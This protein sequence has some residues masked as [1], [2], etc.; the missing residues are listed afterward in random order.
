MSE[1]VGRPV[2]GG[3]FGAEKVPF[4]LPGEIL[5][6][7]V[8][9]EEVAGRRAARCVHFGVCGGCQYQHAEYGVQVEWKR[10]ILADLIGIEQIE[11]VTGEEWGY[12]NRVRMRVEEG[13]VGYSRRGTNEFLPVVMC[14]IA[15][16]VVWGVVEG[17]NGKFMAG[18]AEVEFFAAGESVQVQLVLR[19]SV[20][21]GEFGRFCEGLP[22]GV[23]GVGA[24]MG[25][26]APRRKRVGFVPLTWGAGGMRYG[27]AGRE[28]W[29]SRGAF[30]QVNRFLV[31]RLVEL[32]CGDLRG[33][34]AWDLYAGVGLFSRVLAEKFA[35]VGAV[36][37]AE[38]AARD[39]LRVKGVEGVRDG[40]VEFLRGAVLQ[41]ERPEVVV[42]DPPRAGLGVEGARL[43]GRVGAERV[44]YVSCDPVSLARDLGELGGYRVERVCLVDLFPQTFHLE[45]VVWLRRV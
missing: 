43:L 19:D 20:G 1:M 10:E 24:V 35:R 21:A 29:V 34:L 18:V 36:E 13:R 45:T 28:Y 8:V 11:T 33:G 25:E 38:I 37:G 6:G 40:A 7:G 3:G 15:A 4:V 5:E 41:R 26:E 32:V 2:Y 16:A 42:L 23:V 12:R 30:F 14:P 31:D 39:L 44:V 17:M 27:V 9:V 22:E